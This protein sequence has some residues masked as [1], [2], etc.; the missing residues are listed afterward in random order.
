MN[1]S[2][3]H[4][5]LSNT[6][7]SPILSPIDYFQSVSLSTCKTFTSGLNRGVDRLGTCY[8]GDRILVGEDYERNKRDEVSVSVLKEVVWN[9]NH[10][11][12]VTVNDNRERLYFRGKGMIPT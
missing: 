7:K 12:P 9:R 4:P 5:L 10:R 2:T 1:F 3:L 8:S 11:S 6:L